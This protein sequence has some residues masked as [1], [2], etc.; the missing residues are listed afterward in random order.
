MARRVE[1]FEAIR[2]DRRLEGLSIRALSDRHR[3]HRRTVRQALASALPPPRRAGPRPQPAIEPWKTI[4]DGWLEGDR[5]APPKQRHTA[6]RVWQRLGAEYDAVVSEVTV[7]RYVR[8]WRD[9]HGPVVEVA[10]P[11]QHLPGGEA[12]VDFGEF[13]AVI[14]GVETKCHMFV[15]RLS[16]SGKAV[17]VAFTNQGQ[18]AFLEGHVRAF[19]ELGGVPARI[20]Y[21]NLKAAVSRVLQGRNRDEAERFVALRSHYGFDSFF[22]RPGVEGAHE[23]G[24]V[25][26][27]IGSLSRFPCK[28]RVTNAV[29]VSQRKSSGEED[30]QRVQSRFP[31]VCSSSGFTSPSARDVP[32]S[33]VE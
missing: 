14:G 32:E 1:L 5:A 27:E 16:A 23:K 25:E 13:V 20:R 19:A 3:V 8:R 4:I 17:H 11:Q 2:R 18:E 29:N 24:G 9:A 15:L 26:G 31:A 12:E 10:V 30:D 22:C 28:P 6:R 33:E 21:D 7:S